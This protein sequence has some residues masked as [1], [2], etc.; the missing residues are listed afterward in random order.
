V[1]DYHDVTATSDR[2]SRRRWN[3][4]RAEGTAR[5]RANCRILADAIARTG[6][7]LRMPDRV[8][9]PDGHVLIRPQEWR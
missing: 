1:G 2:T 6:T 8:S 5:F 3:G 9:K 7:R 4:D